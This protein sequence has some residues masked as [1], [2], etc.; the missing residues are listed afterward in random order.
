MD[1]LIVYF[2]GKYVAVKE[3]GI[4]VFDHGFLY[5]DP[6]PG[7][8]VPWILPG[9][10]SRLSGCSSLGFPGLPLSFLPEKAVY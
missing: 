5:G 8:P 1:D 2:N 6:A 3:A 7:R 9:E 4:S 10:Y